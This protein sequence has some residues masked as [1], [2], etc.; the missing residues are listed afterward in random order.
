M[1]ERGGDMPEDKNEVIANISFALRKLEQSEN[2]LSDIKK[3]LLKIK[4][5]LNSY[6]LI[7]FHGSDDSFN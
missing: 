6:F 4:T 2:E 1:D 3:D 7:L 5:D